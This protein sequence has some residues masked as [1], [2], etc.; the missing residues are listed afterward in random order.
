VSPPR[1]VLAVE[2]RDLGLLRD[3]YRHLEEALKDAYEVIDDHQKKARC[4]LDLDPLPRYEIDFLRKVI[5]NER[6]GAPVSATA[7]ARQGP[8]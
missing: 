3:S 1:F 2:E 7:P 8:R 5:L 4:F 6:P